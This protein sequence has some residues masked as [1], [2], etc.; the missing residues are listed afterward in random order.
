MSSATV[1]A[2]FDATM[3][4][5]NTANYF[6]CAN[7]VFALS[8]GIQKENAMHAWREWLPAWAPVEGWLEA[9]IVATVSYLVIDL[10]SRFLTR[11]VTALSERTSSRVDDV[12]AAALAGTKSFLILLLA[13]LIGLHTM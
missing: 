5:C 7:S 2:C 11:R 10:V 4:G 9:L 3:P 1:C 8:S 13:I 6:Y 12:I